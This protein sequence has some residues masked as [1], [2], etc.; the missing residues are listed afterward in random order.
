MVKFVFYVNDLPSP[1]QKAL[2]LMFADDIKCTTSITTIRDCYSL[3]QNLKSFSTWSQQ[4]D[5]LFNH[6][7]CSFLIYGHSNPQLTYSI[8]DPE[9]DKD[10]VWLYCCPPT[11]TGQLTMT[12]S[13]VKLMVCYLLLDVMSHLNAARGGSRI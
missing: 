4:A 6:N 2:L 10:E 9:R 8:N 11:E 5:L 13:V 7:K 12:K 1:L 3:Q